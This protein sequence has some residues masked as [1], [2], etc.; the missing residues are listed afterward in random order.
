MTL[1]SHDLAK[2]G[3]KLKPFISTT[4]MPMTTKLGRGVTYPEGVPMSHGYIITWSCKIMWQTKI[5]YSV[6]QYL[7]SPNLT[8]WVLTMRS[9]FPLTHMTLW[10]RGLASLREIFDLLYL[11]YNK[12]YGHQ[13]WQVYLSMGI[14][15]PQILHT[16]WTL[17][18]AR[19]CNKLKTLHPPP[20]CLWPPNLAGLLD[21]MRSIP[22]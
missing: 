3:D 7:W 6:P 15:H 1:E 2:S 14:L 11:Y 21:S 10:S 20:Q 4:T 18:H 12:A 22:P 16:L 5:I 13:T 19:A 17:G 8:G 9:F